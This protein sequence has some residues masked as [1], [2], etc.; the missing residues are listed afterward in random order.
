IYE[1][2]CKGDHQAIEIIESAG[3]H[4]GIAI[5]QSIKLLDIHTVTIS[6]GV[7]GA[8]S[9][10]HP[11]IIGSLNINLIP[12]LKGKINVLKSTLDD[13]AGVLGAAA[14]VSC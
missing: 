12:P 9:L 1:R 3:Q 14:L 10:L 4:L 11:A 2:A 13:N 6:G 8:W 7:T 5:A